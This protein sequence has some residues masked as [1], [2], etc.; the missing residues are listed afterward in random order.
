MVGKQGE[1]V[2]AV[3]GVR[4][5]GAPQELDGFL[6]LRGFVGE[7]Q[8]VGE[9]GG[10]FRERFIAPGYATASQWRLHRDPLDRLS[11]SRR[12]LCRRCSASGWVCRTE[13]A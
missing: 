4:L 7:W 13:V 9:F 11:I 12:N 2:F 1:M 8:V 3:R 6:L 5:E 10:F